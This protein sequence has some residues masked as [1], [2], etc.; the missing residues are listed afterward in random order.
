LRL[1]FKFPPP[2]TEE[3]KVSLAGGF[4]MNLSFKTKMVSCFGLVS[5]LLLVV[6]A[7]SFYAIKQIQAGIASEDKRT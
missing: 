5:T 7:L 2:H 3:T 1:I 4:T 6:G